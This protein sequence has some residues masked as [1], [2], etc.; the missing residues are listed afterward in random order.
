MILL[1]L[2]L[3]RHTFRSVGRLVEAAAQADERDRWFKR[4]E[5][6]VLELDAP[7]NDVF[8]SG[9]VAHERAQLQ[10]A[11]SRFDAC[12]EDGARF[13]L[14]VA[15]LRAREVE[16]VSAAEDIF[17][18]FEHASDDG[19]AAA[20]RENLLK[21]VSAMSRM[22]GQQM[23]AMREIS[24]LADR[25]SAG[26]KTLLEEH[27]AELQ[28][29]MGYERYFI[30][31]FFILLLGILWVGHHV[32]KTHHALQAERQ[33]AEAER[34]ERLA[35]IGE[36]C[37]SVAHGIR[38]PLAAIR[39]SAQ[40]SLELGKLDPNTRS[41]LEDILTEGARLG[42]RVTGLLNITRADR[43]QFEQISLP[44]VVR[45]AV[46]GL[47]PE[48]DRL[49]IRLLLDAS[50]PIRVL[51]D[52]SQLEQLVIELVSN[53]MEQSHRGG[54]IH[55]R[56]QRPKDLEC[57]FLEVEDHGGGVPAELRNRVF[58]LFFTTKPS[59]TGIGLATVKRI[60]RLHGGDVEVSDG[61]SGAKFVVTFPG[62]QNGNL[63][64]VQEALA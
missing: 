25:S 38:N 9:E 27:E 31:S 44:D 20:Q 30:A 12:V 52:R 46:A 13:G 15:P 3:H 11:R 34:R 53:A 41:R 60:S 37:S 57:A 26:V 16:L 17:K 2:E 54:T 50:Q 36:L 29:R 63:R 18:H 40:L 14:N 28:S 33:R 42:D 64:R 10:A 1:S 6:C 48:L 56:C 61:E 51:G 62:A 8:R 49:G 23:L 39:S 47:R 58:D 19:P 45:D 55:V 24:L 22:D 4:A 5:Q 21:A 32:Q 59:G 35:A 7:G 43:R